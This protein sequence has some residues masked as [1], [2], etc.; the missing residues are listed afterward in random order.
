MGQ[1]AR[2]PA[3]V[4]V[5]DQ[6]LKPILVRPAKIANGGTDVGM[7]CHPD[8]PRFEPSAGHALILSFMNV[9]TRYVYSVSPLEKTLLNMRW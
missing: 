4:R 1:P 5:Y 8:M 2:G 3:V 9:L 6:S 7:V